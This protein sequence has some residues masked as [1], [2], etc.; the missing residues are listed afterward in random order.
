MYLFESDRPQLLRYL[1]ELSDG[2]ALANALTR[3]EDEYE[4]G[5]TP[6][7]SNSLVPLEMYRMVRDP[8]SVV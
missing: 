7:I 6:G 8:H 1:T 4:Y 5:A 2:Q 3:E